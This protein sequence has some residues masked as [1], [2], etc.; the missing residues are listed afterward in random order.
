MSL[1]L[2]AMEPCVLMDKV[3]V[4]DGHGGFI[5]TWVESSVEFNSAITYDT[6]VQGKI[7]QAQG[8]KDLVKITTSKS[9]TLDYHDVLKRKSDGKVYRITSNG[10]NNKTPPSASL[11]MR[12]V[13]AE[14]WTLTGD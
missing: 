4:P 10:Y 1:L 2:D 12:Q 3:R 13:D 14:E 5:T 9:I 6:S 11:D 8:V 7:A